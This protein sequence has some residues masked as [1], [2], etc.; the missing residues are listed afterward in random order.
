MTDDE[1]EIRAARRAKQLI[2]L[3]ACMRQAMADT[4]ELDAWIADHPLPWT[5]CVAYHDGWFIQFK[6]ARGA[7]CLGDDLREPE[8][9]ANLL[10]LINSLHRQVRRHAD[11]AR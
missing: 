6:D 10:H 2:E 5:W 7:P 11:D 9:A 4:A 1:I 3:D 8:Y